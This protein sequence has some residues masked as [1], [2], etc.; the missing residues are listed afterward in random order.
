MVR[1]GDRVDLFVHVGLVPDR[2][3]GRADEDRRARAHQPEA[4]VAG[5]EAQNVMDDEEPE[6]VGG[7]AD[8]RRKEVDAHRRGDPQGSEQDVPSAGEHDEQGI[9]RRMRDAQNVRGGDVLAGVPECRGGGHGRRVEDEHRSRHPSRPAVGRGGV[10]GLESGGGWGGDGSSSLT[11]PRPHA[12]REG[13][14]LAPGTRVI[15]PA[16]LP[17]SATPTRAYVARSITSTMPRC[18]PIPS[19]VTKAKRSSGVT[20][21]PC[22]TFCA[23]SILASRSPVARSHTPRW[24]LPLR[25]ASSRAPSW[26]RARL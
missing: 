26:V 5:E 6:P 2:E 9:P 16:C 23:L 25:V 14:Q 12:S 22:V 7:R 17:T 1:R 8:R 13:L 24:P 15:P 4:L 20:T 11:H 10:R 21:T 19:T 18:P 3:R